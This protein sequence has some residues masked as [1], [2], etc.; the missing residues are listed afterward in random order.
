[1]VKY[2]QKKKIKKSILAHVLK[3]KN[4]FLFIMKNNVSRNEFG[5]GG[6]VEKLI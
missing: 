5:V 4:G 3:G 2:D 6:Q 1:M